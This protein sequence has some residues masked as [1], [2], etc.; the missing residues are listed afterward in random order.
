[1]ALHGPIDEPTWN[2][3]AMKHCDIVRAGCTGRYYS[4][5]LLKW[6][7]WLRQLGVFVLKMLTSA[8]EVLD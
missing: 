2:Y 8:L 5:F 7:I 1:M 4:E 6:T 3:M